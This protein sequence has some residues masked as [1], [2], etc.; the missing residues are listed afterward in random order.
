M[1]SIK[2][3]AKEHAFSFTL[4]WKTEPKNWKERINFLGVNKGIRDYAFIACPN[5]G[6]NS[7]KGNE[8]KY[9]E[10]YHITTEDIEKLIRSKLKGRR[11][12]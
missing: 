9:I 11:H 10:D 3:I 6:L 7:L 12:P 1:K 2:E 5:G 4:E 8:K